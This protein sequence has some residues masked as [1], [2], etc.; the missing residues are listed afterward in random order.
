MST[1]RLID[2]E[3]FVRGGVTCICGPLYSYAGHV[4]PGQYAPDCPEHGCVDW[5][6]IIDGWRRDFDDE[7][8]WLGEWRGRRG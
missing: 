2:P 3:A 5:H 8:D 6:P 1:I 7:L 4:E